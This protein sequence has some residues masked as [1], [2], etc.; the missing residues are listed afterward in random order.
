MIDFIKDDEFTFWVPM[1]ISK[2]DP[3]DLKDQ[4]RWIQG[5]ASTTDVDLQM[6]TVDQNGIDFSYFLKHGYFNN[7]HKPGF[8]NKV[9]QPTE[10]K[11]TKQGLWT[12][13][14][15][16][17]KHKVSDAI[18]ELAQSLEVSKSDRKLG[19]SIQGKVTRRE[20]RRIA[21]CW[22]QD[23]AITAAPINTNTWLD[24]LKS[25][26][27]VPTDLWSP[28]DM[29]ISPRLISPTSKAGG[30]GMCAMSRKSMRAIDEEK[31]DLKKDSCSCHKDKDEDE[32]DK[33]AMTTSS[34][35]APESLDGKLTDLDWAGSDKKKK[36]IA[37]KSLTF[38]D[39]VD[40]ICDVK[41]LS[42]PDALIVA[43]AVFNING[44]P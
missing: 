2:A 39:C 16:F 32:D 29:D 41:K 21:K 18:W 25:L 7:D 9:G 1:D 31:M 34:L 6:E 40:L 27:L 5:I 28:Q 42:R 11:V 19:F 17:Q 15:L 20:G 36:E 37:N 43:E 8:E 33:K 3:K 4:R 24:V 12:K 38:N 30:C 44:Q 22:I 23:V 13:G 10:C 14:F 35:A 26:N